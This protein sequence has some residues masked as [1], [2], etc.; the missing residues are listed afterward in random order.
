MLVRIYYFPTAIKKNSLE[1]LDIRE[2]LEN[3]FDLKLA[4]KDRQLDINDTDTIESDGVMQ[5]E[6]NLEFSDSKNN[7]ESSPLMLELE[8]K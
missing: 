2:E 3:A 6:F 1:L 5:F 4:V 7:N 8:Y